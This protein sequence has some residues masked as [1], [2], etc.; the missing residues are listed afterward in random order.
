V[1]RTVATRIPK[2]AG[3]T[4]RVVLRTTVGLIKKDLITVTMI[5][6]G[7]K[8]LMTGLNSSTLNLTAS[9]PRN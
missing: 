5:R 8:N 7:V 6:G 1:T 4:I 2:T 9:T 3:T